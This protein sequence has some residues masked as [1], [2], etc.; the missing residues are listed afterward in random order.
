MEK[1]P[2]CAKL[3]LSRLVKEKIPVSEVVGTA[4]LK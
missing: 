3:E 4:K 2:L 1:S